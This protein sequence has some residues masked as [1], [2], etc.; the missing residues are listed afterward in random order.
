MGSQVKD[1]LVGY[2]CPAYAAY[3]PATVHNAAG[4][5]T[6]QRAICVFEKSSDMALSR[7]TGWMKNEF[8]AVKGYELVVR[9]IST[10][11][12]Y[13]SAVLTVEEDEGEAGNKARR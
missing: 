7:H 5:S 11:G 13:V 8:G 4:S 12:N 9:S 2:D 6:R 3:L 10:V 1:L